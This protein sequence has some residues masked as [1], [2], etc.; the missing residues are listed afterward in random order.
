MKFKEYFDSIS[1]K[2]C[3]FGILIARGGGGGHG[4]GGGGGHG[5]FSSGGHYSSGGQGQPLPWPWNLLVFLSFV[6]FIFLL[7]YVSS[8][9]LKNIKEKTQKNLIKEKGINLVEIDRHI[10]EIFPRFQKDWSDFNFESMKEY[11]TDA[12]LEHVTLQ[13]QI[14]KLEGRVNSMSHVKIHDVWIVNSTYEDK[15]RD[16]LS[17]EITALAK[18]VLEDNQG[19]IIHTDSNTF[20]E[21]WH[22]KKEAAGWKLDLITQRK[23]PLSKA[24][25]TIKD[26]A[27][28][29]NLSFDSSYGLLSLP[30]QG[31]IFSKK[32][33]GIAE[34][35]NHVLGTHEGTPFEIYTFLTNKKGTYLVS[36]SYINTHFEHIIV[37]RNIKFKHK[38]KDVEL[39]DVDNWKIA[40][41]YSVYTSIDG[42]EI[43]L[44]ILN[45]QFMKRFDSLPKD[46]TIEI[47]GNIVVCYT[48]ESRKTTYDQMFD[49][50]K[51]L[52]D[53]LK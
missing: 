42:P 29:H 27:D 20:T 25:L 6:L 3:S 7:H 21:Y 9:K 35:D 53:E 24:Q 52:L 41:K 32:E 38:P 28:R 37:R 47:L 46:F 17:V 4:G 15:R 2:L 16:R 31:S 18:D 49:M 36:Q 50:T 8:R 1:L 22:F 5:G 44:N 12:Y 14:L 45:S 34:I 13:L 40:Q 19:E 48:Q 26:F 33:F 39:A 43:S 11:V 51:A 30:I 10:F 23:T